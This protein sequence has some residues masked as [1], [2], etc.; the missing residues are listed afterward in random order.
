MVL[1]LA[2]S[3]SLAELAPLIEMQ[4][5]LHTDNVFRM[6]YLQSSLNETLMRQRNHD[7]QA[8]IIAKSVSEFVPKA[9]NSRTESY[10]KAENTTISTY[11]IS[12]YNPELNKVEVLENRAEIKITDQTTRVIEE[13]V[14]AQTAL[15]LFKFIGSPLIRQEVVPWKL[16]KILADREYDV[17]PRFGGGASV[18]PVRMVAEKNSVIVAEKRRDAAIRDAFSEAIVR[19]EKSE[20]K[21]NQ[22]I[23]L[24]DD[25]VNAI[26][27][28]TPLNRLLARLPPLSRARYL[29]ALRKKQL[30][31]QDLISMLTRDSNFLKGMRKKLELLTLNDLTDIYN[32]L[33]QLQKR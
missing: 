29:I 23:L 2:Y 5:R 31:R 1:K 17:P 28:G 14:A 16:E 19:K 24:L 9:K 8:V 3:F 20:L 12:Y 32:L 15:P 18:A 6:N 11:S 30:T 4:Q 22:E 10:G 26:R 21:L 33:R 27:R 25:A 13:S 7:Q